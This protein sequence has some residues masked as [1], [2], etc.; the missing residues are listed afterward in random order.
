MV[1]FSALWKLDNKF[2]ILWHHP[3]IQGPQESVYN[4]CKGTN[5]LSQP[6]L[7]TYPKHPSFL[8]IS[9]M[10]PTKKAFSFQVFRG[11]VHTTRVLLASAQLL[12][13]F[14]FCPVDHVRPGYSHREDLFEVDR[15]WSLE[16]FYSW[17]L[18]FDQGWGPTYI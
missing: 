17:K 9:N 3:T 15:L 6:F 11:C 18:C 13:V 4:K 16:A 7:F 10:F 8:K 12:G 1:I 2:E 14:V 5:F